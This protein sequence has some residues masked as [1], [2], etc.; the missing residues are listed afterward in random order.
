MTTALQGTTLAH[1][2]AQETTGG[3]A[4][5]ARTRAPGRARLIGVDAARG[6]AL[7]GMMSVHTIDATD[8]DGS[9]SLAWTLAAGKSAALFALLAGVGVAFAT[10][11]RRRPSGRSWGAQSG[12][13]LVRALLIGSLGLLLGYAVADDDAA[14]ILP[15][16][17]LLFVLAI[18]LLTL[19][20]RALVA[21][22]VLIGVGLPFLSHRVRTGTDLVTVPN[23]TFTDLADHPVQL[24]Q[25]LALTGVYPALPWMAYLCA[26]MAVGRALVS[27][28]LTAAVLTAVGA[29]LMVAS[30]ATSWFLLD[31]LDGRA[32]LE[33][34]AL[35]SLSQREFDVLLLEGPAGSTPADTY[36]WMATMAPHS[37]TPL[38]IA[39]TIGLGLTVLGVLLLLGRALPGLLR[40]IAA[41]GSMSL[42]L[43]AAHLLLLGAPLLPGGPVD[44]AIQTVLLITFALIWSRFRA[45]G[46]MEDVIARTTGAV[47]RRLQGP[48]PTPVGGE[49]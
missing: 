11:G 17:A 1:A 25:E 16:Y 30:T 42:T 23:P 44:L 22:A 33:Q 45:R 19:P 29:G 24:L 39:F 36:W 2:C 10:G 13:L 41:A 27:S 4:D 8:S 49:A 40:P 35:G 48:A 3:V 6:V 5:T 43:Y 47:R 15:Y 7:I 37:S 32:T 38:D 12:A 46:P 34:V 28:R 20:I 31:V 14:V 26:G 9:L 21:L 18:P